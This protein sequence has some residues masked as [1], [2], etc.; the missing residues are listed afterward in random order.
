MELGLVPIDSEFYRECP[1]QNLIPPVCAD[2][3]THTHTH[4]R[5]RVIMCWPFVV[6]EFV[7]FR[8]SLM[9]VAAETFE[10]CISSRSR[11]NE[12]KI[13]PLGTAVYYSMSFPG[14]QIYSSCLLL[15]EFSSRLLKIWG[16]TKVFPF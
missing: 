2:R 7:C 1:E 12:S 16:Y 10:F 13:P 3:R 5:L 6:L 14:Q 15:S 11:Y 9:M 4:I 8:F